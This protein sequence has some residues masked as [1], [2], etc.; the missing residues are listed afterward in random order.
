MVQ[1]EASFIYIASTSCPHFDTSFTIIC[2]IYLIFDWQKKK[3]IFKKKTLNRNNFICNELQ[4][5]AGFNLL[6]IINRW[7]Y[8][9]LIESIKTKQKMHTIWWAIQTL[10]MAISLFIILSS[11]LASRKK[12]TTHTPTHTRLI[13]VV[14]YALAIN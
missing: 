7:P 9:R 5:Y 1:K 11:S 2:S 8:K 6:F 12:I 14:V 10:I 13:I 3:R 4:L